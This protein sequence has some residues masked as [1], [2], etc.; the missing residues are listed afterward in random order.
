MIINMVTINEEGFKFNKKTIHKCP[1]CGTKLA[2]FVARRV[3]P[4]CWGDGLVLN[5]YGLL[6]C[7]GCGITGEEFDCSTVKVHMEWNGTEFI[8]LKEPKLIT[9]KMKVRS[10]YKRILKNE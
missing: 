2:L 5:Q 4:L 6:K 1:K 3:E 8:N 10:A 7:R 9:T